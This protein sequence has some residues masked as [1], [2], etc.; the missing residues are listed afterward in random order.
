MYGQSRLSLWIAI[1]VVMLAAALPAAAGASGERDGKAA[2]ATS[3]Q[4][5]KKTSRKGQRR[6]RTQRARR[7]K[8]RPSRRRCSA[9]TSKTRKNATITTT[10]PTTTT[11][12]AP[13][14]PATATGTTLTDTATA[15]GTTLTDTTTATAPQAVPAPATGV[16]FADAFIGPDGVIT[17][18]DAYWNPNDASWARDRNWEGE[19]GTMYRGSNAAASRTD[20]TRMFRFWTT[21][22]DFA[23]VRVEMDLRTNSFHAGTPDMPAVDWDGVKLWL[24]R[25]VV[26]GSSSASVAPA[27]YTAEVSRRQ[28]NV[29]IQKKCGGQDAYLVLANTPWSG[30]PNPAR[31]GQWERVG[32]SVR[33]NADGSVT[34]QVIRNG[35]VVLTGTDTGAGGCPPI[36]TPGKVGVRGDN[37]AFDFDNFTVTAI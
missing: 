28:G 10:A 5:K 12:T 30:N 24:R 2:S 22:S 34:V 7:T 20:T 32:G 1:V 23:N 4:T 13:T 31:I 17:S 29:V 6:C 14:A 25:Q 18:A 19:S 8:G 37:T 26:R 21:R 9:R 36:T 35:A 33:T 11:G 27:L 3:T 15:T 16:L